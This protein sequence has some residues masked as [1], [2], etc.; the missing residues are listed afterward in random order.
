LLSQNPIV[1]S[2]SSRVALENQT[3]SI[4]IPTDHVTR[5]TDVMEVMRL[6]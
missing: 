4:N 3:G 2:A 5:T 6:P 1:A